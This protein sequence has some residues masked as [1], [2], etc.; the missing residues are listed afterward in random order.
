MLAHFNPQDIQDLEG[1]R[2]A[3][4][5]LLNLVE[6]LTQ[7]NR[8]QRELIQQQRDEINRLKGE[9]GK[10][11]IKAS[12]QDK[13]ISSEK[14]RKPRVLKPKRQREEKPK[15]QEIK[16][17]REELL[18][19]NREELPAD[20]EFKGYEEVIVQDVRLETDNVRFRKEKYYSPS[21]QQTYLAPLPEGYTGQFGPM[22]RALVP[23]LYYASGMSEPKI[24]ELLAFLGLRISKGT[25]A[26]WLSHGSA[27]WEQEAL[28]IL[29]AGL[30]SSS[31]QQIDDTSTRVN[32][33]NQVC[34]VLGNSYYT[35]YL[36]R[37]RKDRLTVITIL[38]NRTSPHYLFNEQTMAWLADFNLP[39]WA[40]TLIQT[41]HSPEYRS[42]AEVGQLLAG[43]LNTRL[44]EQQL[45]RIR[46][47][48][49]LTAYY[50]QTQYPVVPILLSDDAPQFRHIAAQQML[51]WVHEGRHYKKLTPL[52]AY[53]Q[54]IL[55]TVQTQFWD[56]YH[57]LQA[58]QIE[59]DPLLAIV[60]RGKFDAIFGQ[61]TPY[62]QLNHRLRQTMA[63]KEKLLLVLDHPEVPLHNNGAELAVRQRVR[64]RD[65]SFGPRTEAGRKG[66][67]VFMTIV[68]TAKKLGVDVFRYF[69]DKVSGKTVMPTLAD[70][71]ATKSGMNLGV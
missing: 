53:H 20:A 64:K 18:T 52:V 30:A 67:D 25:V 7:A 23:T 60:L 54:E 17:D 28:D 26:Q 66:W 61:T 48:G 8:E 14:E 11:H 56:Y 58:Y 51:C 57:D 55:E 29:Q 69:L 10:P 62:E 71:I 35:T 47:A 63:H 15:N 21:A 39:Q 43:E 70:L 41:W 12:R 6:E 46:E 45:A 27:A 19:V 38:Q 22:V 16:I 32:G 2:I 24:L 42:E 4:T 34:H 49:A 59:P 33:V 68:A 44:N 65:V 37:P 50:A 3:I 1:A 9:Q 40:Q 36:T 5:H 13:D 31:W